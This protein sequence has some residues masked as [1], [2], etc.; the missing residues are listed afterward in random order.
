MN[1]PSISKSN[2]YIIYVLN[3]EKE[4]KPRTMKPKPFVLKKKEKKIE[5][6]KIILPDNFWLE[7]CG[8]ECHICYENSMYFSEE[9][10]KCRNK[11]CNKCRNNIEKC[12]FCRTIF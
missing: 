5:K 11:C 7:G 12:P 2:R 6:N 1:D 4:V 3:K 10:L 8:K 9:C